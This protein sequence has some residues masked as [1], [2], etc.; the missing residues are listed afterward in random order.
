MPHITVKHFP[1][2]LDDQRRSA[3]VAALTTAV[4]EALGCAE[5]VVSIALE[6]VDPADWQERVYQPEIV[7]RAALLCKRPDY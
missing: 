5:N 1:V 3:L 2:P 7:A 6:P 4:T